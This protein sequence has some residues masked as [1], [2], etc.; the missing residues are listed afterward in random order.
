MMKIMIQLLQQKLFKIN[1]INVKVLTP[2][3]I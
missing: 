1:M 3:L 2:Y